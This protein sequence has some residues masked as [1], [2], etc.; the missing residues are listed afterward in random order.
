MYE[1]N[2]EENLMKIMMI[3]RMIFMIRIM[4]IFMMRI[5]MINMI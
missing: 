1:D 3:T 4:R 5:I 2:Y